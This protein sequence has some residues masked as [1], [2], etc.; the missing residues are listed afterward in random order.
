MTTK[1]IQYKVTCT[2]AQAQEMTRYESSTIVHRKLIKKYHP[3]WLTHYTKVEADIPFSVYTLTIEVNKNNYRP[4]RWRS[5][6]IT[7]TIIQ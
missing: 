6:G 7:S 3:G 1:L 5:F 2:L 4:L